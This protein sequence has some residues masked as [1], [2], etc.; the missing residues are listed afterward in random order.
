M[1]APYLNSTRTKEDFVKAVE[2]LVHTDPEASWTFICD[3]L[4]T[5]KSEALVRF[6]S[7][8]CGMEIE[9]GKKGNVEFSK[10][11]KAGENFYMTLLIEY[12]LYILQNTARG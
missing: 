3:G 12:D 11:W 1:E 5:H 2:A 4:N 10:A 9:L 7:E 8:A 6:V